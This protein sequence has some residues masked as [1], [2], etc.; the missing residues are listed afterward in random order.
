MNKQKALKATTKTL[1]WTY[2]LIIL[3][4]LYL[5]I[6]WMILWSFTNSATFGT[7]GEFTFKNY[8][9][10]FNGKQTKVIFSALQNTLIIALVASTLSTILGTAAA[11]GIHSIRNKRVL[12]AYK[13]TNQIPMVNSE[14]VTAMS[15]MLLFQV[16]RGIFKTGSQLELFEVILAHTSFCTPYVIL[17]VSPRLAQSDN[18]IYEAALDLG[19]NYRQAIF[20]ALIPEL[21]PGI[22]VGFVMAFTLSIDDF[23][24]TEFTINNR[25]TISTL[26]YAKQS[27]KR[28]LPS[29][30]RALF[31]IIFF[32]ILGLLMFMNKPQKSLDNK[33]KK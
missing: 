21:L 25:D 11:I 14:I 31:T 26:I 12:N 13:T 23:V 16:F 3:G 2:V 18:K 9:D 6:I 1:S 27:G 22:I 5:P 33:G 28:A 24:I 10:L 8:Q 30:F 17:N 15:M 29:E 32:I 4:L 19:C 7:W 20:K